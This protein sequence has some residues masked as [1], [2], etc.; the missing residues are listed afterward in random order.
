MATPSWSRRAHRAMPRILVAA[1]RLRIVDGELR[2]DP[3]RTERW[4][5]RQPWTVPL[6]E[7]ATIDSVPRSLAEVMRGGLLRRL[8]VVDRS[9]D[10]ELFVL[11]GGVDAAIEAITSAA[12]TQASARSTSAIV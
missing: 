3:A 12:A 8:R 2:F 9:G 1:G 10:E 4:F 5:G 6:D 7:I 11:P